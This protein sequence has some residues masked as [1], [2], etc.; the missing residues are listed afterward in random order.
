VHVLLD[1]QL[2]AFPE[3]IHALKT[4]TAARQLLM[5]HARLVDTLVEEGSITEHEYVANLVTPLLM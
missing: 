2:P 1:Q 4:Q 5:F 3:I